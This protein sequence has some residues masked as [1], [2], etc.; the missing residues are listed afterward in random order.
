MA[1]NL[2]RLIARLHCRIGIGRQRGV[3][4]FTLIELLVC[5][6]VL[7]VLLGVL[8]P[9]LRGARRQADLVVVLS[10]LRDIGQSAQMYVQQAD[11]V[12]PFHGPDVNAS[13]QLVTA[14]E[15]SPQEMSTGTVWGLRYLWF[16]KMRGV[17]SW[18][19]H[20][21]V[22]QGPSS[23]LGAGS[24]SVAYFNCCGFFARPEVWAD[25]DAMTPEEGIRPVSAAAV[26]H[27]S[28]KAMFF[29]ATRAYL[30]RD[31]RADD[32][33]GVLAADG[34]AEFRLDSHAIASVRNRI[35]FFIFPPGVY[36]GTPLGIRGRDF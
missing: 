16:T 8:L 25:G 27:P 11:G 29:D 23:D 15:G 34:A 10:N 32:E 35:D 14:S 4:A 2:L 17:A 24:F 13:F 18:A 19:E 9:A 3:R 33:R 6:A 36:L 7:A 21:K 1:L 5:I 20:R 30:R 28:R 26:L 12:Y 31:A 22:W